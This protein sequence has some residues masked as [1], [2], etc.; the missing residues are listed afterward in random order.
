MDDFDPTNDFPK[1]IYNDITC[2][3]FYSVYC[4]LFNSLKILNSFINDILFFIIN[5]VI[6]LTL[7]NQYGK[8]LNKKEK[9]MKQ[10]L[11]AKNEN[12]KQKKRITRMVIIVSTLFFIS[13]FPEFISSI[14]LLAYS[15]I[16]SRVF[17]YNL[18]TNLINDEAQVFTL[19]SISC[20][21]YI[22]LKFNK[23]FY[24]GFKCLIANLTT[25]IRKTQNKS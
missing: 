16:L 7:L 24:S 23:N 19:I 18:S 8:F 4:S 15:K 14:L 22:F 3:Q 20:Q 21:F 25:K 13:H 12:K 1:E 17:D 5:F 11:E 9:I 10:S 2:N 6:D